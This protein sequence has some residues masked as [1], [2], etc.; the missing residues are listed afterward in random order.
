MKPH[1][2]FLALVILFFAGAVFP[3]AAQPAPNAAA[4]AQAAPDT[5]HANGLLPDGV[6]NWDAT[7]KIVAATNGQNFAR[8]VFSFTNAAKRVNLARSTNFTY[9]TNF[10][11][12]TN[13]GFWSALAGHKIAKS[14]MVTTNRHVAT[15]TNSITPMPLSILDAYASCGC[16][17]PELPAKPWV[18]PPGTNGL[19]RVN[20][21]LIGKSGS[22][23]KTLLVT[24]DEGKVQLNL[25]VNIEEPPAEA[26]LSE[27]ER[28]R[29]IAA[30]KVDRQ[31]IFH[32]DCA[33]CHINKIAGVF[34]QALFKQTCA[35]CHEVN[36][37]ASMVPDLH[38]LKDPTSD[39]F[40]RAWITSGKAGT[41]M[42]AFATAQGGPLS[43]MQI[44][45]LAA[46]LDLLIPP[47]PQ[48]A[49]T[50]K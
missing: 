6:L 14:A 22:L 19:L 2:T 1:R 39:Q 41:L 21:S 25:A 17:Q 50:A 31:A 11:T 18:L 35:I 13:T 37:R 33:G 27:A 9:V 30:A 3:I 16:T 4:A 32:G 45:S 15:V 12:V 23:Y 38:H 40:W 24:T 5:T 48:P 36:P 49:A 28:A 42:P 43:D 26:T 34:G 46:Y 10:I 47:T 8:F 20:V 44:A 29:G 7:T